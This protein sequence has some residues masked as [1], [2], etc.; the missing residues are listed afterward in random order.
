MI[1]HYLIK[2][3]STSTPLEKEKHNKEEKLE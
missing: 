3:N 1:N 2:A